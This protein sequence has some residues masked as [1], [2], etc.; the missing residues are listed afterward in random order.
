MF[1]LIKFRNHASMCEQSDE[2]ILICH[3]NSSYSP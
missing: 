3:H 1:F 2:H